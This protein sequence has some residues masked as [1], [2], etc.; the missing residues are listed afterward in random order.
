[1]KTVLIK[2]A[3]RT[4]KYVFNLLNTEALCPGQYITL[5]GYGSQ[6]LVLQ[7]LGQTYSCIHP[8]KGW[9]ST[10][11]RPGY[12]PIK[13]VCWASERD[14]RQPV[15]SLEKAQALYR[16]GG[17][18]KDFAL[19]HYSISVLENHITPESL[20]PEQKDRN[21]VNYLLQSLANGYNKSWKKVQG[22]SGYFLSPNPKG[23]W[24]V[25]V[26]QTVTYPGIVYFKDEEGA[27][28]ALQQLTVSQ[29]KILRGC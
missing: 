22:V 10:I 23:C 24:D 27:R 1:M 21:E 3:G 6:A 7:V 17:V 14:P 16:Q 15:L 20:T 13:E 2:F 28:K 18:A 26:H 8:S 12:I 4:K 29:R 5:E 11:P 9:L 19:E 25:L